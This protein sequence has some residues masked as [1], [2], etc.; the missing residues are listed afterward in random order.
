MFLLFCFLVGFFF[1]DDATCFR[2]FYIDFNA[3]G[4]FG[5]GTKVL[6]KTTPLFEILIQQAIFGG[7]V[8]LFVCFL[9]FFFFFFFACLFCFVFTQRGSLVDYDANFDVAG[10]F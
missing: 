1:K 2:F 10:D 5:Y 8:C 6:L 7:F 4:S 3:E 9:C